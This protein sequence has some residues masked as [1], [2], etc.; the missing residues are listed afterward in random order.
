MTSPVAPITT[1]KYDATYQWAGFDR[2]RRRPARVPNEPPM[3]SIDTIGNTST[4]VRSAGRAAAAAAR[5]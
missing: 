5:S 1:V 4:K 3:I 2:E